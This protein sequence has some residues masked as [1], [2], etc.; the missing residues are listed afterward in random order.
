MPILKETPQT[1]E[2]YVWA[3]MFEEDDSFMYYH[4]FPT[5]KL[6]KQFIKRQLKEYAEDDEHTLECVDCLLAKVKK[7]YKL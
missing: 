6:A 2:E 5:K 4:C 1:N 7:R 3:A